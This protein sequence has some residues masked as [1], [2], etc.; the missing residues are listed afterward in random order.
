M[1]GIVAIDLVYGTQIS[2]FVLWQAR[3]RWKDLKDFSP[4]GIPHG[5]H[6]ADN[7][8]RGDRSRGERLLGFE[9][10]GFTNGISGSRHCFE[11]LVSNVG[12]AG[13]PE[14]SRQTA[15]YD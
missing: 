8:W 12:T 5:L 1:I 3:R 10:I 14:G 7:G 4:H 15:G 9:R 6:S 11:N 2:V 13:M